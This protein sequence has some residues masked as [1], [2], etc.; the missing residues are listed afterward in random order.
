M[1]LSLHFPFFLPST[2]QTPI[3]K[4]GQQ[5]YIYHVQEFCVNFGRFSSPVLPLLLKMAPRRKVAVGVRT[6]SQS[7]AAQEEGVYK[8]LW[9]QIVAYRTAIA[10]IVVVLGA[11]AVLRGVMTS[12]PVDNERWTDIGIVLFPPD[13]PLRFPS[14]FQ[15]LFH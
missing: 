2:I 13:L 9:A 10:V 7:R 6:R 4:K 12:P 3:K 15:F 1:S 5:H 14:L 11:L 8:A